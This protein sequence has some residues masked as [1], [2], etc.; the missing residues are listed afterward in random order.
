MKSTLTTLKYYDEAIAR[1]ISA[2]ISPHVVGVAITSIVT[3][4]YAANPLEVLLWLL[5]LMPLLVVPPLLYL[6]W[7]V[8][9]GTLEDIF[10]PR[11]ETR[12]RPLFVLMV[13]LTLCVGLMRYWSAPRIVEAF[14]MT[15]IALIGI[16]GCVTLFWKISFHGATIAAAVTAIL[17]VIG[18]TALP[19]VLLI[20]LVGWSR[21][22]LA[23]HTTRQVI[24]GSLVGVLIAVV[25]VQVLLVHLIQ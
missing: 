12:A 6:V 2:V 1:W 19:T 8:R 3:I 14:V 7:L 18:T 15:S 17:M 11:R 22:R 13:W 16:L 5:L 21:V 23:R 4:Q 25:M 10:M 9:K 24:Y 20:P